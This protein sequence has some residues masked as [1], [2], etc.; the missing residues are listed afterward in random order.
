MTENI[1]DTER[2][3][4]FNTISLLQ[5]QRGSEKSKNSP[6]YTQ[7]DDALSTFYKSA[8]IMRPPY[9]FDML[10]T[11]C[12][13]CGILGSCI[14]VYESNIVKRQMAIPNPAKGDDA[15][16]PVEAEQDKILLQ[17]FIDE[18]SEGMSLQT[19]RELLIRDYEIFGNCGFEV[20]RNAG[21]QP[22]ILN[23]LEFKRIRA[24]PLSNPVEVS[25]QVNRNGMIDVPVKKRFRS[26]VMIVPRLNKKPELVFFKEY[27]DPRIIDAS[28]GEVD[29]N[30]TN[31]ATEILVYKNGV[32]TYGIPRWIGEI[33]KISG[34]TKVDGINYDLFDNQGIPPG[35][36]QVANGMLTKGSLMQIRE[37]FRGSKGAR[38]FHKVMILEA[39][40]P[41]IID[42]AN[43]RIKYEPLNKKEDMLFL[44]Y[45][46]YAIAAIVHNGF[47]LPGIYFGRMAD[48]YN[49]ATAFISQQ[50]AESQIFE[51]EA[52]KFD[53]WFNRNVV[54][55]ITQYYQIKTERPSIIDREQTGR[56]LDTLVKN[57][58]FTVNELID[59]SNEVL[60]LNLPR[61]EEEWANSLPIPMLLGDSNN[62]NVMDQEPE[63]VINSYKAVEKIQKT[64]EKYLEI[65][66]KNS[67]Y[68]RNINE[69][70]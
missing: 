1:T 19:L 38:N 56:V 69:I 25:A 49:Y 21:G 10:Y 30:T 24:C 27:G 52:Q 70:N 15:E 36:I 62:E 46:D 54:K 3:E 26:Y 48:Q 33:V 63:D 34:M 23:Y 7:Y 39:L 16:F 41:D 5:K 18:V 55:H 65:P 60:G 58:A 42:K 59:F 61:Y 20:V 40:T 35:I 67:G 43:A 64:I 45:L 51:K 66:E 17:D 37:L 29:P 53:N 6:N 11:L 44:K 8:V 13:D 14:D 32:G 4:I 57:G 47:R 9:S 12:N 31:P 2:E 50:V 68:D 28:T 22:S